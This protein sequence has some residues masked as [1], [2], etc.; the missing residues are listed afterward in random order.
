MAIAKNYT[1]VRRRE[2]RF[3]SIYDTK[4]SETGILRGSIALAA[5]MMLPFNLIGLIFCNITGTFWYNPFLFIERPNET[6]YFYIFAFALP[7]IAGFTLNQ[8]KIQ[9]YK[10]WDYLKMYFMPKVPVNQNG[11]R[12]TIEGYE[13]NTEIQKEI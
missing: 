7:I 2:K 3:Y 12:I 4:I 8:K 9:G 11:E 10:A 5:L 13:L 1:K 6:G